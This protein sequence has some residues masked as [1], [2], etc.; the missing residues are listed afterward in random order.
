MLKY[1]L[2]LLYSNL[3][4]TC[5]KTMDHHKIIGHDSYSH[6]RNSLYRIF[7]PVLAKIIYI[8]VNHRIIIVPPTWTV[9]NFCGD[10]CTKLSTKSLNVFFLL[11]VICSCKWCTHM[12]LIYK[13]G[14]TTLRTNFLIFCVKTSR[15]TLWVQSFWVTSL[16]W[17][18]DYLDLP[19]ISKYMLNLDE[20]CNVE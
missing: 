9:S 17:P 15:S 11:P 4:S 6:G 16:L 19:S 13:M 8:A 18:R 14:G 10:S 7:S 20:S 1:L 2:N 5:L 12:K 3:Y